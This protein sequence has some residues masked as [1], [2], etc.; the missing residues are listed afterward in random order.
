MGLWG[1][2]V[3]SLQPCPLDLAARL[4]RLVPLGLWHLLCPLALRLRLALAVL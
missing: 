3:L 4:L 1:L 2:R